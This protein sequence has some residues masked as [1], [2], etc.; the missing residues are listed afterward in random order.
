MLEQKKVCCTEISR[1][2]SVTEVKE[3]RAREL[4]DSNST[5]WVVRGFAKISYT[6]Y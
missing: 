2:I 4:S 3:S 6:N 5:T 1:Q